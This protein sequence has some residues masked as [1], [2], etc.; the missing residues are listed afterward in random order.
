MEWAETRSVQF[1]MEF[2][3]V[4]IWFTIWTRVYDKVLFM[5][6]CYVALEVDAGWPLYIRFVVLSLSD[7]FV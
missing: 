7:N 1:Q 4:V 2:A 3:R 6:K 5:I